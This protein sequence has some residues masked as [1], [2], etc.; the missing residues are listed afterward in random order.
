MAHSEGKRLAEFSRAVRESSLKRLRLVPAGFENWGPLPDAMTFVDLTKHLINSDHWLFELLESGTFVDNQGRRGLVESASRE[1][2]R[3]LLDQLADVGELRASVLEGMTE[4]QLSER[5]SDDRLGGEVTAWWVVVRGNLDHEIHHRGQIA[6][7]LTYA[8]RQAGACTGA[9]APR[10]PFRVLIFPYRLR[11]GGEIEYAV[12][13]RADFPGGVWQGIAGGGEGEETPLA[14]A[15]REANEEAGIP[16]DASFIALDSVATIPVEFVGGF[17]WDD[18]VL[19]EPEYCFGVQIQQNQ[20]L[21]LSS[22]HTEFEWVDYDSALDLLKRDSNKHAL[23][24][25]NLRLRRTF[26]GT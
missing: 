19:V 26:G 15:K 16:D 18:D 10:A 1:R 17:L 25:L 11:P 6:A 5:I 2:Y 24:E 9:S 20:S 3:Q 12:F 7:C 21:M 8:N 4:R 13:R 14:A 22:E 23:W